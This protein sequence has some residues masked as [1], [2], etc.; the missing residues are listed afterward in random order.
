MEQKAEIAE[1]A[2][3]KAGGML[4]EMAAKGERANRGGDRKTKSHDATLK[5]AD[6]GIKKD[7]S[8]RWQKV[9]KWVAEQ[10][11]MVRRRTNL[12]W[13]HYREVAALDLED[14]DGGNKK[15]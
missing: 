3:R 2:E 10:I 4:A 13:S 6:L 14:Q 5:L 15:I 1:R 8:S 7:E 11:E 12:S 9:P